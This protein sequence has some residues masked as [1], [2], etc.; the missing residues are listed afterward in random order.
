MAENESLD[1]GKA[2]RWRKVYQSVGRGEPSEQIA[3]KACESLHRTLRAVKKLIPFD[4]L[5][6]AACNDPDALPDLIRQCSKGRDFARL[7]QEVAEKGR[8]RENLLQDY[9]WAVCDRFLDQIAARS[10]P[11]EQWSSVTDLR[12][13]LYEVRE[14]LGDDIRHIAQKLAENPD[15]TARIRPSKNGAAQEDRTLALLNES[16]L[17]VPPK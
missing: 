9:L 4:Q 5:L 11:S 14:L 3:R 8:G 17:P 15:W 6:S 13:H 16:L 2:P 12:R 10:V 1:L 7:F